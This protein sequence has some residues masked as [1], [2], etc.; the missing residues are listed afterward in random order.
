MA[1]IP[2]E[3]GGSGEPPIP[4]DPYAGKL[5]KQWWLVFVLTLAATL[6]AIDRQIMQLLLVP[7]KADLGLTDTQIS[8]LYGLAFSLANVLFLLP[9]GYFADRINRRTL[10]LAGVAVWSLMT[11]ACGFATNYVAMFLARSGVGFGESVIQPTGVSMLRSAVPHQRRGRAFAVYA[12]AIMLGTALALLIGGAML[13]AFQDGA[14]KGVPVLGS[15]KPWQAVLILLGLLG[16]PLLLFVALTQEPGR[17]VQT[18]LG[19]PSY[20]QTLAYLHANRDIF[21]PLLTF[22]TAAGMLGLGFGAWVVPTMVRVWGL[23]IPQIGMN[24]GLMMLT[25]PP[26]GLIVVGWLLDRSAKRWQ[27]RGPLYVGLAAIVLI[28]LVTSLAPIWPTLGGVWILL[29]GVMLTSGACLPITN[30]V[31][32]SIAPPENLGRITGIQYIIYGIFAGAVSAT[33]IA[34]VSD[35]FFTGDEAIAKALSLMCVTYGTI[36]FT[37][38]AITIRNLRA[39]AARQSTAS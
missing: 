31:I 9:A 10:L 28:T 35:R 16:L 26:I 20:R 38:A 11:A 27:A 32:A 33:L 25:L 30:T 5:A 18:G 17:P 37:A 1:L 34:V 14:L 3:T 6:G 13:H 4:N 24:L 2:P 19:A 21:Y 8:L 15:V 29:A 12:M 22:N 7:I 39:R 23:T 36:S